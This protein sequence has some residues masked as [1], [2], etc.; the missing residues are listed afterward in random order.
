MTIIRS[1]FDDSG[2]QS[3]QVSKNN[4]NKQS[5]GNSSTRGSTNFNT[6][7]FDENIE[8]TPTKFKTT[9]FLTPENDLKNT[10]G[11]YAE[12]EA[13]DDLQN[14]LRMR[15]ASGQDHYFQNRS[16]V[17]NKVNGDTKDSALVHRASL[18]ANEIREISKRGPLH[19]SKTAKDHVV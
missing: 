11:F 3:S 19:S 18:D 8:I 14:D 9:N 7:K 13:Q 6:S 5:Y 2:L 12:K 15:S 16:S 10:E 17:L 1:N 4:T